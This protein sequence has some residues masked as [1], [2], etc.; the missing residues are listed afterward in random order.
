MIKLARMTDY[1]LTLAAYLGEKKSAGSKNILDTSSD[2]Y[3]LNKDSEINTVVIAAIYGG[4][5]SAENA[6]SA[7]A[8]DFE[9]DGRNGS[10]KKVKNGYSARQL[11]AACNIPTPAASKVLKILTKKSI[12]GSIQGPTGGYYLIADADHVS[13]AD[14][15]EAMD[16]TPELMHCAAAD[17]HDCSEEKECPVQLS[18]EKINSA[19]HTALSSVCLS[20]LFKPSCR[21]VPQ[22]LD[23][24]EVKEGLF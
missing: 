2:S 16:G 21:L 24:A 17:K 12:L 15:I 4:K 18:F 23:L 22:S 3:D 6:R 19:L 9:N 10:N 1:A 5:E 13:V 11:S 7:F 8:S 14:I 20:D